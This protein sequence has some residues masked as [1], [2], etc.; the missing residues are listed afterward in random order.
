[1][2]QKLCVAKGLRLRVSDNGKLLA[3][4]SK[5]SGDFEMTLDVVE[6]LKL[7]PR[8]QSDAKRLA[9]ELKRSVDGV[10][11]NLPQQEE[12]EGLLFDLQ[13]AGVV[14]GAE[15]QDGGIQD[16]FGD[17]WIQWA[18]VADSVRTQKYFE[19]LDRVLNKDSVVLDVG[20][21]TGVFSAF[22]LHKGVK[23][24][25]AIEET[26]TANEIPKILKRMGIS[27]EGRFTLLR[28]NSA[29]A[30]FPKTVNVVV[31]ELFGNDPLGEGMMA[32]LA[33]IAKRVDARSTKFIPGS[34]EVFAEVIDVVGGA[35][36]HRLEA[37]VR[38][39]SEKGKSFYDQFLLAS[40]RELDFST[41]S[42]PIF[43][44]ENEFSAVSR[45]V[46][47][48]R[49]S[50]KDFSTSSVLEG[51]KSLTLDSGARVPVVLVW[52]R[53]TLC[54][55]V[56]VS[57]RV[58]EKDFSVHWS[59]LLVPLSASVSAGDVLQIDHGTDD[60]VTQIQVEISRAGKVLGAR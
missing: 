49:V 24:V 53:A 31:S 59:P 32:T 16:G 11:K 27:T 1:M 9:Q 55:G 57:S 42:F 52:F 47:L 4:V 8:V 37:Y 2:A 25:Y 44:S 30:K 21:G 15:K 18:M 19:A 34:F 29:D 45:P 40:R 23:H 46:S 41:L 33:D 36:H 22:A 28:G 14:V 54:D 39:P 38:A 6:L 50:L 5:S 48:G 58:G 43:L 26:A 20:A 51:K 10:A 35:S 17:P 3:S 12:I 56:T 60:E 7:L 13:D